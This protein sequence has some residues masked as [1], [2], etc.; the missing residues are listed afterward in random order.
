M[1]TLAAGVAHEIRNPLNSIAIAAQ[2]LQLEFTPA[3]NTD[4]YRAF[5]QTIREEIE[6]LNAII[7]DFL[8]LARGGQLAKVLVELKPYLNEITALARLEAEKRGVAININVEPG[9]AVAVDKSEMKK[10]FVN[11]VQNALQSIAD[12]GDIGIIAGKDSAGRIRID[13]QNSGAPIPPEDR[14]RIFQPYFTTR[15]DGT[16]L[17]LAICRRIVV[18]HGGTMELLDGEPTTFRI[19]L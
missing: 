13:I 4:E 9:L 14:T 19:V 15:P 6:R 12:T 10:V 18:D 17:G 8:A 3:G 16:G 11:L 1:G 2:R 5:L 7:K